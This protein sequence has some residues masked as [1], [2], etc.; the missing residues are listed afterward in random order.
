[1]TAWYDAPEFD[2]YEEERDGKR[3]CGDDWRR[4]MYLME[5]HGATTVLSTAGTTFREQAVAAV[6]GKRDVA[7][8]R[9]VMDVDPHALRVEVGGVHVGY[10]PRTHNQT[11]SPETKVW[12]VKTGVEPKPHVWLAY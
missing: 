6:V 7:L 4:L 2:A 3:F 12:V 10:V 5:T 1:M 9:E 11:L 8:V